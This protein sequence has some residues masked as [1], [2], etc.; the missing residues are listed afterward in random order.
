[1]DDFRPGRLDIFRYLVRSVMRGLQVS[2]STV[3]DSF[4]LEIGHIPLPKWGSP[5]WLLTN[6]GY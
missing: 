5:P 1:M 3:S 4:G 6:G 2:C